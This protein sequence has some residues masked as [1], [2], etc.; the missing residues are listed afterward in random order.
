MSDFTLSLICF[1]CIIGRF[2]RRNSPTAFLIESRKGPHRRTPLLL[3]KY[4]PGTPGIRSYDACERRLRYLR[5]QQWRLG[6]IVAGIPFLIQIALC[7][8]V[9]GF[10]VFTLDDNFG[11]GISRLGFRRLPFQTTM[12]EFIPGIAMNSRYSDKKKFSRTNT[13]LQWKKIYR[14]AHR[15]PE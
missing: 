4:T 11:I 9:V 13:A 1:F 3:A 8:F 14:E 7:L 5:A 6:L 2:I 12:S 15:E 10:V